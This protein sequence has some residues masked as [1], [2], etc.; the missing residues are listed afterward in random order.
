MAIWKRETR[1]WET[2]DFRY[3]RQWILG[4]IGTGKK[5][6]SALS[7]FSP[8]I[9]FHPPSLG[10]YLM[11]PQPEDDLERRLQQLEA[12]MKSQPSAPENNSPLSWLS[13]P[14]NFQKIQ[15]WFNGLSQT[16]KLIVGG[17][18]VILGLAIAQMVVKAVVSAIS[19]AL[20]AGLVYLGYKFFVSGNSQNK[21]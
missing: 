8:N 19:L 11:S 18:S 20:L 5:F 2:Q 17:V 6:C 14:P 12:E 3:H 9:F 15:V 10:K 16:N 13:W 4:A 1:D 21:P 7:P